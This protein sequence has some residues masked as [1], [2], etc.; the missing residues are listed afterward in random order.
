MNVRAKISSKGQLVLPKAV[1]DAHGLGPG[2]EV[3]VESV[4][5]TIVLTP[6][7]KPTRKKYTL[8]EVA[9]FLKYD[10]PPVSIEDMNR[11]IE[12]EARRMWNAQRR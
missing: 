6:R 2:S 8:E 12:K 3:E 10:G 4:G 11:A 1:R 9:G 7:A 5:D